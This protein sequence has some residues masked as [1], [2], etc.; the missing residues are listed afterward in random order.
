MD[1]LEAICR[2]QCQLTLLHTGGNP[3]EIK[4]GDWGASLVARGFL[5]LRELQSVNSDLGV[6]GAAL[7]AKHLV[8]L[9]KLTLCFNDEIGEGCLQLGRFPALSCL[10][11]CKNHT[12]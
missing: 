4:H 2:S 5:R 6:E 11:V 9:S 12:I 8:A 10:S 3:E 1:G 7:I